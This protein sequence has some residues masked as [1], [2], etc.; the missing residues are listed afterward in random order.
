MMFTRHTIHQHISAFRRGALRRAFGRRVG[1]RPVSGRG[2]ALIGAFLFTGLLPGFAFANPL[3]ALNVDLENTSISGISSG[4]FMAVQWHAAYADSVVGIGVFAGGPYQCAKG[5]VYQALNVCMAGHANADQSYQA[6]M[7]AAQKGD[8][9]DPAE[10]RDDR[11]WLYSGYNDGVVKQGTM[12]ALDTYYRRLVAPGHVYYKD[13][14][15]AGHAQITQHFGQECAVTGGDFINDCDLDGA[16]LLLQHIYGTLNPKPVESSADDEGLSG[17]IIEFSQYEYL[18]SYDVSLSSMAETGYAYVPAA[19]EQASC[20]LHIALHGC[21]QYADRIG[22]DFYRHAGYNAWADTNHIVVLYPQ[23]QASDLS[24]MNPKGC[25]DW[26]G[27]TGHQF[28]SRQG[29]QMAALWAMAERLA[30]A[31]VQENAAHSTTVVT[32]TSQSA[33]PAATTSSVELVAANTSDDEAS[34]HWRYDPQQHYQ[35]TRAL[36]ADGPYHTVTPAPISSGSYADS[37]LN[38]ETTYFYRLN[39]VGQSGHSQ[40]SV[41]TGPAAPD[42]DPFFGSTAEHVAGMRATVAWGWTYALGSGDSLGIYS[43]DNDVNLLRTKPLFYKEGVC[44]SNGAR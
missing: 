36:A 39:V 18:S 22:D 38:A 42:C 24:P 15:D 32:A 1:Y 27:Y 31:P 16:G 13:N 19:C 10:M 28:A 12:D 29:L 33:A 2:R 43:L 11:V 8:I 6:L 23:T 25:W 4:A 37:G 5:G 34:F 14:Q 35:L 17:R 7:Q 40:V 44:E 20:R 3:P 30:E 9:A 41:K 21:L 26:W